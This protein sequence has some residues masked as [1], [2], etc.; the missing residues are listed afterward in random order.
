MKRNKI[1]CKSC[2]DETGQCLCDAPTVVQPVDPAI[3]HPM[4][5]TDG[6]PLKE[7]IPGVCQFC[8]RE[9]KPFSS[10]PSDHCCWVGDLADK[11]KGI[12][13]ISCYESQLAQQAETIK[14]L[15]KELTEKEVGGR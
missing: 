11:L 9:A 14:I 10:D 3:A 4:S 13:S 2:G 5:A 12:R 6:Y 8:G 15:E 7:E 1:F